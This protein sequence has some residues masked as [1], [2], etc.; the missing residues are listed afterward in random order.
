MFPL[1]LC[2]K[3]QPIWNMFVSHLQPNI[4]SLPFLSLFH[5]FDSRRQ[6]FFL[7]RPQQSLTCL[8]CCS[9]LFWALPCSLTSGFGRDGLLSRVLHQ[10]SSYFCWTL[11][12][13]HH[14]SN[15]FLFLKLY[16]QTAGVH[17]KY[18]SMWDPQKSK[19]KFGY[20]VHNLYVLACC[21][22]LLRQIL[23]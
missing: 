22:F 13:L 19:A 11:Q 16:A 4:F 2:Q 7:S 14:F 18:S 9:T 20:T 23:S 17:P 21:N 10:L 8:R 1:H 15:V 3:V 6:A 12:K 5:L